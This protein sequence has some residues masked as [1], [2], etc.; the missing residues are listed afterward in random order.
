MGGTTTACGCCSGGRRLW[1]HLRV[2][3]MVGPWMAR[4]VWWWALGLAD[5]RRGLGPC[6]GDAW[7]QSR[8]DGAA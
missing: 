3:G 1:S 4:A 7:L 8:V 5:R 2:G 6:Y